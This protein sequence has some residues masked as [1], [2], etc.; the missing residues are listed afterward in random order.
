MK[1]LWTTK[2]I[3][4]LVTFVSGFSIPPHKQV[5]IPFTSVTFPGCCT[6]FSLPKVMALKLAYKLDFDMQS[7]QS[8]GLPNLDNLALEDSLS[9]AVSKCFVEVF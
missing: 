3:S 7:H 4:Y 2:I 6:E 9:L 5:T 8:V 1:A